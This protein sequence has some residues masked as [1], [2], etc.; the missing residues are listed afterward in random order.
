[1][2]SASQSCTYDGTLTPPAT[3]PQKTG[4]TFKG[5][6][7]RSCFNNFSCGLDRNFAN[8]TPVSEDYGFISNDG[9]YRG[10]TDDGHYTTVSNPYGLT[11]NGTWVVRFNSG[12]VK[13][14]SM[15]NNVRSNTWEDTIAGAMNGTISITTEEELIQLVYGSCSSDAIKP[16]DAFTNASS[17]QYCWCKMTSWTP[18][19]GD[20]CSVSSGA[21]V[22][23]YMEGGY[24]NAADCRGHCAADCADIVDEGQGLFR[25]A[26]FGAVGNQ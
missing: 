1:M 6:R 21:W 25:I 5:W 13:G 3:I 4:Y 23:V 9:T 14:E 16:N 26:V 19:G 24:D 15:C 22:V 7:V 17:G 11:E 20:T 12:T 2:P 18:T 8:T 10:I